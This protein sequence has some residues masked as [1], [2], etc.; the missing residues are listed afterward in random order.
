MLGQGNTGFLVLCA[1]QGEVNKPSNI[2]W[3]ID[4]KYLLP[5]QELKVVQD[6]WGRKVIK[7]EDTDSIPQS[8]SVR[9]QA[10]PHLLVVLCKAR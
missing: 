5:K 3:S 2:S 8:A 1:Q 6:K 9:M 10:N 7:G 4:G